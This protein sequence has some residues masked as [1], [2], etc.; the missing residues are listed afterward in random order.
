[1]QLNLAHKLFLTLLTAVC[2]S[3]ITMLF[4]V[5]YSFDR[6][7]LNYVSRVEMHRVETLATALE[8]AYAAQGN[9]NFLRNNF[10]L[11]GELMEESLPQ[12]SQDFRQRPADGPDHADRPPPP[13]EMRQ[14]ESGLHPH[15]PAPPESPMQFKHRVVLMDSNMNVLFGPIG[16]PDYKSLATLRQGAQTIGYLGLIAQKRLVDDLQLRF[17]GEQKK[18]FGLIA[19]AISFLAAL[20]SLPLA[21]RMVHRIKLLADATRQ[22]AA[23]RYDTRLKT[24][25]TDELGRL[26]HD[27]NTLATTLQ[28]N[29]QLRSQWVADISH[30]LRTPLS[31][32]RGEIEAMQD[33]IRPAGPESL[34]SLH[35]EVMRLNRLVDD[36][37]QLSMSDIGALT[38]R[39]MRL[40]LALLLD[41]AIESFRPRFIEKNIAIA[42]NREGKEFSVLGDPDRLDQLFDNLLDNSLKYTDPG[43]QVRI[44]LS[45][46]TGTVAIRIEDSAPGIDTEQAARLFD[47]LYRVEGSRSRATGGSGLGLAICKNIVE[48]H[49]GSIIA[50]PSPLQGLR[51]TVQLPRTERNK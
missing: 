40:D 15:P 47:R 41:E 9:W 16:H 34:K 14:P 13:P 17:A 6:G 27:F 46:M 26:T 12:S 44:G 19:L 42:S 22:L 29:E 21:S 48:A 49:E 10:R 31:V 45:M 28:H 5:G 50:E 23:G 36:L 51:I 37:F 33:N 39:K 38:Y 1:M 43:G 20:L 24:D 2:I 25:L 7:F 8:T 18:A 30:E 4:L 11:W 32:L 35:A 3:L